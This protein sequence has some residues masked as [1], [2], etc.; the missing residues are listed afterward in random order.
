MTF[1]FIKTN[2]HLKSGT[3]SYDIIISLSIL[4]VCSL[5]GFFF[6]W[7]H[8]SEANIITIYILGILII[9]SL[10]SHWKY[11]C[12]SSVIGMFL[13]NCLYA[14]PRFTLFFYDWQYSI[15]TFIMLIVSLITNSIMTMFRR[16]VAKE[17]ME[18]RKVN[19]RIAQEAE[20]ERLR[21]NLLRTISHD[22][23][24]PL[25]S[26]SGNADILLNKEKKISPL[27]RQQLYKNIHD[28]SE[29]LINMVEN[30]LFV[31]RIENGVMSINPEI[32]V[33]Q[34]VI[35][36]ALVRFDRYAPA[37]NISLEMDEKL[38]IVKIDARLFV[39][40]L[41]NLVDN[42]VKYT[43]AG[44]DIK[45]RVFQKDSHAIIEVADMGC[46]ISD[47]EKQK[48]FE[49]FYTVNNNLDNIRRGLGFG[50]SLCQSV[51]QAHGGTIQ[52][53]DNIPHGTVISI[54]LIL[55]EEYS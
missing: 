44:S 31:T 5:V 25:T 36:E 39:H 50:L 52:I 40:V 9:S 12:A 49:M 34:E 27:V 35:P 51:V 38:L 10:T 21:A 24:T 28:D 6:Y 20:A 48:V 11:G 47:E 14:E 2:E 19:E 22:L 45:I 16:Q 29:W 42:A 23:R 37:H 54:S 26:I 3:T 46:G 33:L 15:T 32:E 1:N 43:P 55:E 17:A 13:F 53:K 41:I 7:L 30:L 8:L 18:I 4:G